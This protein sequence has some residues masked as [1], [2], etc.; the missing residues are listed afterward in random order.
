MFNGPAVLLGAV[1]AFRGPYWA[2]SNFYP[3]PSPSEDTSTRRWSTTTRPA[4]PPTPQTTTASATRTPSAE[5]KRLGRIIP[6][7][8]DWDRLKVDVMRLGL[9]AKF[10]LESEPGAA[11]LS[12]G[13][14]PLIEGH[15]RDDHEGRGDTR[16]R[17]AGPNA[18]TGFRRP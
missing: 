14:A 18:G 16:R 7:A 9:S 5:A 13:T 3:M 4:R 15:D 11:L 8:A 17:S 12:T 1:T 2:L 10:T 6:C